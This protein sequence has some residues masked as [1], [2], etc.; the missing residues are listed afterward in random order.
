MVVMTL[1]A[2]A[3]VAIFVYALVYALFAPSPNPEYLRIL[4]TGRFAIGHAK[5]TTSRQSPLLYRFEVD[6]KP[7]KD[8]WGAGLNERVTGRLRPDFFLEPGD[9]QDFLVI[10]DPA[11]PEH[12][13]VL[14]C[15]CPINDSVDF[16]YYVQRF[17]KLR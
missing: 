7:Y 3:V 8:N 1:T 16:R 13:N 10:Y 9:L 2:I 17:E 15:D 6:G 5:K 12:M 14:R 11:D 4:Q